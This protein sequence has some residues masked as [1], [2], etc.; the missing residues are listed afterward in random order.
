[1]SVQEFSWNGHTAEIEVDGYL[2][3]GDPIITTLRDHIDALHQAA[4]LASL[5]V[6]RQP[7]GEY[8][9]EF[10]TADGRTWS[11]ELTVATTRPLQDSTMTFDVPDPWKLDEFKPHRALRDTV[12]LIA[13]KLGLVKLE[14]NWGA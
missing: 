8:V 3:M 13:A 6:T 10:E 12:I 2:A 1:M 14:L 4:P 11:Q 9:Y 5:E 7:G